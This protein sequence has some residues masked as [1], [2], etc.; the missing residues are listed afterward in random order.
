MWVNINHSS[1]AELRLERQTVQSFLKKRD[2]NNKL[3]VTGIE[4]KECNNRYTILGQDII[5][6]S[7]NEKK[8]DLL[9]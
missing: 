9:I 7:K 3:I 8:Y 5:I 6:L 4:R 1:L 2:D